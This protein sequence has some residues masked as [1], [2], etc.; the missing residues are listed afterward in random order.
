MA[1]VAGGARRVLVEVPPDS[2]LERASAAAGLESVARPSSSPGWAAAP[3]PGGAAEHPWD[4]AHRAV[5]DPGSVGLESVAPPTYA[6]P[7]FVQTFPFPRPD[8]GGLESFT[9][10]P[11][12]DRA[13]DGFWPVGAPEFGWHLDDGH[14]QLRAARTRAGDPGDGR[15][16]RVAHLDTGYDPRHSTL[17]LQVLS[18]LARNFAD[19]DPNDATDPGRHFPGNQPGHGTATLALLAGNRVAIPGTG[20]SDFLGGAPFA[21]V[22]PVRIADSVV[23]FA[24]SAM[25]RGIEY[26]IEA[27]CQVLSVS[28]GGV[29]A[30]AW[31]TAVNRA[32]DAGVAMFA[33]A[34][35]R[36]GPSPPRMIVYPARFNRVVA[37]CGVTADGRPYYQSQLHVHMQGC[38]GPPA[39]MGTALAAYTPNTPWAVMG[40]GGSVGFGGG[41]SSATPQAAAAAALWLQSVAAPAGTEPW[42]RVEAVRRALF[43]S[44]DRSHPA[45]GTYFGRGALRASAALDQPFRTDL[46][47]TPA[48]EVSFGWLRAA[49]VLEAA[50]TGV[51]RMFEVE[52]LQ[53]FLQS[54]R[55]QELAG[56]ADPASDPLPWA[57]AKP[58]LAELSRSPLASR[59]L[60]AHLAALLV[61]A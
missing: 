9:G 23:H 49:G 19:G 34:G 55:V 22:V 38:F 13:P 14:S 11:C 59:A 35:N 28:M 21:E 24:T 48:D 32:Y 16:V 61:R 36:F 1:L 8:S 29:P 44:A 27:G 60:R 54:P 10:S 26:A 15:R 52:A 47:K 43:A 42:Q 17:P 39:K 56:G 31:A 25:A 20:F 50:P 2:G 6:E 53:V 46:P 4:Q 57:E 45:A 5:R 12:E 3:A 58:V 18:G 37:V 41:T 33:A 7:D 40:C 30:R 51:E